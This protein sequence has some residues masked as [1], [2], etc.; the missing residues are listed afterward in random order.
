MG[1]AGKEAAPRRGTLPRFGE[2]AID[3]HRSFLPMSMITIAHD[4]RNLHCGRRIARD[5][6]PTVFAAVQHHSI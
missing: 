5:Q 4:R 2:G 6:E 1:F 3:S